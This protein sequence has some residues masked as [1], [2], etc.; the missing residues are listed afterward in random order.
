MTGQYE[1]LQQRAGELGVAIN[2][3]T[4]VLGMLH[5]IHETI[6]ISGGRKEELVEFLIHLLACRVV[7]TNNCL[8]QEAREAEYATV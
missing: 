8:S 5:C 2:N 1:S 6:D 7:V 3:A 4:D